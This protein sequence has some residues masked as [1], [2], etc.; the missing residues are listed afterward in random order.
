MINEYPINHKTINVSGPW[1]TSDETFIGGISMEQKTSPG[2]YTTGKNWFVALTPET[3]P[4]P[5]EPDVPAG[6]IAIGSIEELQLIGNDEDYPL[7][8]YYYLTQNIDAS[9]TITWDS[10]K[11]F[12][13]IGS[14]IAPFTGTIDGLTYSVENLYINRTGDLYGHYIGLI[15]SNSGTIKNLAVT[16]EVIGTLTVGGLCGL[17]TGMITACGAEVTVQGN[18]Q[19]GGLCGFNDGIIWQCK[20]SGAVTGVTEVGGLCGKHYTTGVERDVWVMDSYASG[21][22]TGTTS[23]G[24]LIGWMSSVAWN[25]Y[26]T[27]AVTGTTSVGGLLGYG[28]SGGIVHGYFDTQTSGQSD[29]IQGYGVPRTTAAMK[30]QTTFIGYG[31]GLYWTINEGVDYP[32]LIWES[33]GT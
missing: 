3:P 8:K 19:V 26:S 29:N 17:N 2:T 32:R 11:G 5:E 6:A 27:G 14:V 18:V 24:G 7:D 16:G 12:G 23:V 33:A 15:G 25:V 20:A 9:V 31:F 22:V 30:Q 28:D 21:A 1:T 4:D 10:G 13:P